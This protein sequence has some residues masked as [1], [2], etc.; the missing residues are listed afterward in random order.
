MSAE[1]GGDNQARQILVQ[2]EATARIFSGSPRRLSNYNGLMHM[3]TLTSGLTAIG[4]CLLIGG[5]ISIT[6]IYR[7]RRRWSEFNKRHEILTVA[8]LEQQQEVVVESER[9]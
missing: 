9:V 2:V 1:A 3:E 7:E 4:A 8:P 5:I 6:R